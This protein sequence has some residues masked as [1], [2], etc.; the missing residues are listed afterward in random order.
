MGQTRPIIRAGLP[1]IRC[2]ELR[3]STAAL[4]PPLGERP[5]VVQECLGHSTI[6][7]TMNIY[8]HVLADMQPKAA[9]KLDE[10]IAEKTTAN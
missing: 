2:H 6:G 3:H 10:L 4:L 7:V 8:S 1:F 5:K 9:T